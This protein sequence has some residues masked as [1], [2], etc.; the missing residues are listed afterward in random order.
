MRV[1]H[2]G[3]CKIRDR[4]S[5]PSRSAEGGSGTGSM[6]FS[7]SSRPE[8]NRRQIQHRSPDIRRTPWWS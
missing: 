2:A 4:P 5:A 6:N 7:R 8:S 3:L 1:D